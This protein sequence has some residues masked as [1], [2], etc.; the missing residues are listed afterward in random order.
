VLLSNVFKPAKVDD[1]V[2]PADPADP[3]DPVDSRIKLLSVVT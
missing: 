2:D 1:P 3:A